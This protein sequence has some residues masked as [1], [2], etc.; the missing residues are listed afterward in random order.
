MAKN[1]SRPVEGIPDGKWKGTFSLKKTHKIDY[2]TQR[3]EN[4]VEKCDKMRG[5]GG[6]A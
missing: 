2:N 5:N 6:E 4:Q 1:K 3:N